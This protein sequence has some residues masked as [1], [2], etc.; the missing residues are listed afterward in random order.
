VLTLYD[1]NS[2]SNSATRSQLLVRGIQ[3]SL[4]G[5]IVVV[6]CYIQQAPDL[7]FVA[8]DCLSV[9]HCCRAGSS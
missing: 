7:L 1:S 3:Q 5:S 8:A 4:Q 2:S 6:C 9:M